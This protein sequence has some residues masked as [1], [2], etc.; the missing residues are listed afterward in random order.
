VRVPTVAGTFEIRW[1]L[2]H[3]GV[4]WFSDKGVAPGSTALTVQ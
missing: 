1:D 3:E 2:V 4:T